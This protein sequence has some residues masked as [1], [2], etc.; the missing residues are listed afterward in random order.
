MI[1]I[2]FY[3]LFCGGLWLDLR[4]WQA[5]EKDRRWGPAWLENYHFSMGR[6]RNPYPRWEPR[7]DAT[8]RP[9]H[10]REPRPWD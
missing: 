3:A 9:K 1:L 5:V 2:F 6:V 10:E 7:L 4:Q 8:M